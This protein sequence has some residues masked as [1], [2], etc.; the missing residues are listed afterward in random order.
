MAC[1][2]L[3]SSAWAAN[4]PWPTCTSQAVQVHT[5]AVLFHC[6]KRRRLLPDVRDPPEQGDEEVDMTDI[7]SFTWMARW[8]HYKVEEMRWDLGARIVS[9][10]LRGFSPA[11]LWFLCLLGWC[12]LF[13][14]GFVLL[15]KP[16]ERLLQVIPSSPLFCFRIP[17][18]L[19]DHAPCSLGNAGK[20]TEPSQYTRDGGKVSKIR[21]DS[22]D[23]LLWVTDDKAKT[24]MDRTVQQWLANCQTV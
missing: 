20:K 13:G 6:F 10:F 14:F 11:L 15:S 4:R 19:T 17:R 24:M 3:C 5:W 18:E 23:W 1:K 12:C 22:R 2:L 16:V 7:W 8:T 9:P 21:N